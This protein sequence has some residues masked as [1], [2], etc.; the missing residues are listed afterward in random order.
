VSL[1]I[2]SLL[3]LPFGLF[4]SFAADMTTLMKPFVAKA[5]EEKHFEECKKIVA[6]YFCQI[7]TKIMSTIMLK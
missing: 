2:A 6:T 1:F 4:R 3:P 5:T 7:V